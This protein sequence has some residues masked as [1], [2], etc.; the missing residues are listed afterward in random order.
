M[1]VCACLQGEGPHAELRGQR[2]VGRH[3]DGAGGE[4]SVVRYTQDVRWGIVFL[5]VS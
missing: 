1:R 3:G 2:S 5:C 4:C